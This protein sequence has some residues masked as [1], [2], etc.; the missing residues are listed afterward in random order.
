MG[1]CDGTGVLIGG[2]GGQ[3]SVS[4]MGGHSK[5][6]P[7]VRQEAPPPQN[8]PCQHQP[9]RR[10]SADVTHTLLLF[11]P[12]SLWCLLQQRELTERGQRLSPPPWL[13]A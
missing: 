10:A 6:L 7:C 4:T 11:Q 1:P 9:G 3:T 5:K 12:L 13:C 8:L 2:G